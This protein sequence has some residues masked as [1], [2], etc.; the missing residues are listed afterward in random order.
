MKVLDFKVLNFKV[1]DLKVLDLKVLIVLLALGLTACASGPA[2]RDYSLPQASVE[3]NNTPFFPQDEYQCGPAALATVLGAGGLTVTP[4][5][6]KPLIYLP[7]R[8]GSLQAEIVAVTRRHGRIPYII[9]PD[10]KDLLAE[11]AAGTPVLVMQNLGINSLP[12][13]HYAVVIGYDTV[14]DSLLLR[15]GTH[16]RLTMK[17]T[18]FQAT[19]MRAQ[20][21]ALVA[22][23]PETPPPTADHA[24][25]LL[26]ASAF[27]E[28][29]Q[30]EVAV[31]A[32]QS[33]TLR[34]PDQP[35]TWQ[36]LA[37]ARYALGELPAA[38]AA[39]RRSV[40]LAPSAAAHNNL[41]HVLHKR[42][43]LAEARVQ[44]GLAE[45]T[46]DA[47]QLTD[48]LAATRAAIEADGSKNTAECTLQKPG[49][50]NTG[51]L[52]EQPARHPP[53]IEQH[54]EQLH[55]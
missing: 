31:Q 11:V 36:A 3:L 28:L 34:W 17:R 35:L 24:N 32:Y 1:L 6:L 50:G 13:W 33:A 5:E 53:Q 12:Q 8:Q 25:W 44:I 29:G 30:P 18:R 16:E 54:T 42:G 43:C 9:R 41:A 55:Q 23:L 37:N 51:Y 7:G 20:N 26:P 48:V 46:A 22:V 39:L 49:S 45:A 2:L 4:D 27:E 19:W 10:M 38:E 14:S 52:P 40:Q 21:W 47:D 15:S